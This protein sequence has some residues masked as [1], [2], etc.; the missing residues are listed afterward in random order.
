MHGAPAD[1]S[2]SRVQRVGRAP[3]LRDRTDGGCPRLPAPARWRAPRWW[4]PLSR[5]EG[6]WVV[7]ARRSLHGV[8]VLPDV[9]L[10]RGVSY[11]KIPEHARVDRPERRRLLVASQAEAHLEYRRPPELV[12][13][14]L[15][16]AHASLLG[17]V[18]VVVVWHRRLLRHR[19]GVRGDEHYPAVTAFPF[20]L[21]GRS[22]H[23]L[24][25]ARQASP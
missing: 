14:A 10:H 21:H 11:L 9:L 6:R 25:T 24:P 17:V 16:L 2:A 19:L 8:A 5:A 7:P 20:D 22:R 18:L 15:R 3:V 23:P 1:P 13:E 12:L 4:R